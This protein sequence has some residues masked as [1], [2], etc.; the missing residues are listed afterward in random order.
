MSS[1]TQRPGA[2]LLVSLLTEERRG[3]PGL[4]WA[5]AL[6]AARS[7][8]ERRLVHL[9]DATYAALVAGEA[10]A[11]SRLTDE[12]S[13]IAPDDEVWRRRIDA[14]RAWAWTVDRNFYP[15][16][17]G[18]EIVAVDAARPAYP[19]AIA[20]DVETRM[21][22]ACVQDVDRLLSGR[23]M[24]EGAVRGIPLAL[25]E[26]LEDTR[27]ALQHL[28]L[29]L[30]SGGATWS[31]AWVVLAL[32][33]LL[34]R[35]GNDADAAAALANARQI[36]QVL[37][38]NGIDDRV[39]EAVSYLV[40][41]DWYAT[42]GSSPEALGFDLP[43]SELPSPFADKRDDSLAG[44]AYE[45]AAIILGDA[46]EPRAIGALA[47]RRAAL[48]WRQSDYP[49]QLAELMTAEAAFVAAGE[50][51]ASWLV[52]I[53]RL[54]GEVAAGRIAATRRTAGTRF[55]LQPRGTI[56][57]LSRWADEDGSA[58]F[59]T[60][61]GRLLQRV[62][63]Q[64]LA[65]EDYER[66]EVAYGMAVPLLPH[67]G[68][69]AA[70]TLLLELAAVDAQQRLGVRA[71]T[72]LRQALAT[73][74]QVKDA[75]LERLE[76]MRQVNAVVGITNAHMNEA[77]TAAGTNVG[78]LE[79]AI[80][81]LRGLLALPGVPAPGSAGVLDRNRLEE[82]AHAR[83]GDTFER[84][85][86]DADQEISER[87][88]TMLALTADSARQIVDLADPYLSFQRG[89]QAARAGGAGTAKRWY[90]AALKQV[91]SLALKGLGVSDGA[92]AI[93]VLAAIDRFDE[94]RA[95]LHELIA[96]AGPEERE[97]LAPL[98]VRARDYGTALSL[99]GEAN[100][101]ARNRPWPDLLDHAEAALGCAD[102]KAAVMLTDA[103]IE[104]FEAQFA[105]LRR[106]A[107]RVLA[108]DDIKVASLYLTAARAQIAHAVALTAIGE[109][110][111]AAETRERAFALSDRARALALAALIAAA[112]DV[113]TDGELA[114]RW[115]QATAEWQ[116]AYE[117]LY[118]AYA[119]EAPEDE[120]GRLIA[121]LADAEDE[122]VEV[123]TDV[124]EC[125]PTALARRPKTEPPLG[126]HHVQERLPP[127]TALLEYQVIDRDLL[128]WAV[129]ATGAEHA[130]MQRPSGVLA[131]L[132]HAVH[133]GC[134]S[135]QPGAEAEELSEL[136]LTPV[137]SVL[138][139]CER[140]I[141]VPYGRLNSL[142]FHVL[143]LHGRPLGETHVV[144]YLPAA[145]LL[146]RLNVD[147]PTSAQ[148]PLVVGDP[149]F[150]ATTHPSLR[151]LPGAAV[152]ACAVAR[153][154]GVRA[155]IDGDANEP[156]IRRALADRDL[157]HLAAH[158]RLDAI[159]PSASS[160]ILAGRDELTVADLV[161]LHFAADLAVLSACDSGRGAA[162]LGGDVVGL[163]RGLFAAGVRRSVVSLWP[164]DDAPACVTMAL[165]HQ[166]LA[167]GVAAAPALKAAQRA[168]AALSG[169]DIA[170]R[171]VA[172]GGEGGDTLTTRRRGAPAGTAAA[173]ALPLDPEFVD[174]LADGE[175]LDALGGNLAR[176]WAPFIVVGA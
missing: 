165:F 166:Q 30:E 15:G 47:L 82:L 64:W 90:D 136:L 157:V 168:V 131:R 145:S 61:L 122:I 144:S 26:L 118:R 104:K 35:A 66:A 75:T 153:T 98:A 56:A 159:A 33:D 93:V 84:L 20:N 137:A 71:T 11:A 163:T 162:S 28:H 138:A 148:K 97:F 27:Q 150:D 149:A 92:F 10:R 23:L 24:I 120:I 68:T 127:A 95:R 57:A 32:A 12:A 53:H 111:A 172:L 60:G 80:A 21:L 6:E 70:A 13:A 129:T 5:S 88:R 52:A 65:T 8:Q 34:R 16:G 117:R 176:V 128:I 83:A 142:P 59:T 114:R 105:R 151:R 130:L 54:I 62:G 174:D 37:R 76:W 102:A 85:L 121:T 113:G 160:I 44:A 58:S 22:E 14:C 36:H 135:H 170:E 41:G 106:D 48:A 100:G 96:S 50:A 2:Q 72:R 55:D 154:H 43:A 152:E 73:L 115:R 38:E 19:A 143:P 167:D 103:A 91:D 134:S 49:T 74:P 156:D 169:A 107:D 81:R 124:E 99:F 110:A 1:K 171:Y 3:R 79:Q 126:L 140:V 29:V 112:P 78:G 94:A 4:A 69:E 161:G 67:S 42:P 86:A 45:R 7:D 155:W 25:N 87:E 119:T 89:G 108:S 31:L 125:A 40:E 18:A 116:S 146:G 63:A 39:G 123:E 101:E 77:A 173:F 141:V 164:V 158:G 109:D 17:T 9:L 46:D 175:P 139:S 51:A 132:V 147:E 133:S